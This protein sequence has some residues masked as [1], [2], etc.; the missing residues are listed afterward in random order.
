M[1]INDL[2]NLSVVSYIILLLRDD[3][4]PLVIQSK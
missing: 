3:K 2:D 1:I 4:P